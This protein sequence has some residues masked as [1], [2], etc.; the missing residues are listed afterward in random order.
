MWLEDKFLFDSALLLGFDLTTEPVSLLHTLNALLIQ[1]DTIVEGL[2]SGRG[3]DTSGQ[4]LSREW[5]YSV[6]LSLLLLPLL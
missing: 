3:P 1:A 5:R 6:Y 4:L 2:R